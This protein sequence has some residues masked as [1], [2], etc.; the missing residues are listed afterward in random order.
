MKQR[1][2]LIFVFSLFLLTWSSVVY[3]VFFKQQPPINYAI[4]AA[5][6]L[7]NEDFK[8]ELV[9]EQVVPV[10]A[11]GEDPKEKFPKTQT[12]I[13]KQSRPPLK[14]GLDFGEGISVDDVLKSFG[15]AMID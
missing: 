10:E 6:L 14:E 8:R 4:D 12:Q 1:L 13:N 7:V 11:N 9:I 3:Q 2:L 15:I 5:K